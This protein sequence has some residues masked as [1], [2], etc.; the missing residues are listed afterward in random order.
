MLCHSN[1]D[2]LLPFQYGFHF[3]FNPFEAATSS[4]LH[5]EELVGGQWSVGHHQG[6]LGSSERKKI[7]INFF[8]EIQ[9]IIVCLEM[10]DT[11]S[12]VWRVM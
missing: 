3:L 9:F 10:S 1:S 2:G 5:F 12:L 6:L 8:V 4:H 7:N 11:Y